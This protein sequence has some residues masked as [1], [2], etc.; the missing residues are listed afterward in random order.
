[1]TIDAVLKPQTASF[2]PMS[3]VCD[4]CRVIINRLIE[5][6]PENWS[7]GN[8][9]RT[10]VSRDSFED[11]VAAVCAI[12]ETLEAQQQTILQR[13]EPLS[14]EVYIDLEN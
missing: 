10:L 6:N 12:E 9:N 13:L 7:W 2:V 11:A 4:G 5:A 3:E 1:M 8:N 14:N